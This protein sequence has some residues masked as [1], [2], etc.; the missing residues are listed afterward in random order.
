MKSNPPSNTWNYRTPKRL[1]LR[2]WSLTEL[3]FTIVQFQYKTS[4][5][6]ERT[7][8]IYLLCFCCVE[9]TLI[10]CMHFQ[11]MLFFIWQFCRETLLL[12]IQGCQDQGLM[13]MATLVLMKNNADFQGIVSWILEGNLGIH[14]EGQTRGYRSHLLSWAFI[15]STQFLWKGQKFCLREDKNMLIHFIF[16]G[17]SESAIW[18][19][20]N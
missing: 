18:T 19:T 4:R 15:F 6:V 16:E 20:L 17:F 11:C 13:F 3:T 2:S 9:N 12:P 5:K 14:T 1:Q 7:W 8:W 10:G